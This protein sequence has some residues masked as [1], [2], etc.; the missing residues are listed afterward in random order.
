MLRA[1]GFRCSLADSRSRGPHPPRL[2]P[3]RGQSCRGHP[4]NCRCLRDAPPLQRFVSPDLNFMGRLPFGVRSHSVRCAPLRLKTGCFIVKSLGRTVR[5][6]AS[7][8]RLR[9]NHFPSWHKQAPRS[10]F[11]Q[12][13]SRLRTTMRSPPRRTRR[14]WHRPRRPGAARRSPCG[15]KTPAWEAK[16]AHVHDKQRRSD[17]APPAPRPENPLVLTPL[18][19]ASALLPMYAVRFEPCKLFHASGSLVPR[20]ILSDRLLRFRCPHLSQVPHLVVPRCAAKLARLHRKV[21]FATQLPHC[22]SSRVGAM[23]RDEQE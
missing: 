19:Q 7:T 6:I 20:H 3:R 15:G 12:L 10:P 8:A 11:P 2:T 17:D 16:T 13:L 21:Q 18:L 14:R 23:R 22:S 5:I 1:V 9:R 4:D